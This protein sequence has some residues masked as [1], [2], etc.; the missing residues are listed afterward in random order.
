MLTELKLHI[1]QSNGKSA[2]FESY[3]TSPLKLGTPKIDSDRLEI[4]LMM[5]SAGVLKGDTFQYSIHCDANTK[6]LLTEQSYTKIFNTGDG[7]AE[8]S[9]TI[10]LEEN[11]S[12]YYRPCAAVPFGGSSYEGKMEVHLQK[13][14]EFLYADIVTA[15]RVGMGER[16]CFNHYRNRVCV[17]KEG[18]P[19]WL[20]HCLLE[21]ETMDLTGMLFFD[22]YTHQ[23]TLYY[24]GSSEREEKLLTFLSEKESD[25]ERHSSQ[26]KELRYGV[27]KALQGVCVRILGHTAQDIEEFFDELQVLLELVK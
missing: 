11:A 14:S 19:V 5:A 3:F 13:N 23:G 27:S 2:I 10:I 26:G 8:K 7:K 1:G 25:S 21:P 4:V 18:R 12:L 9:Q 16:F 22:S 15:G 6:T 17:W 20:D 24:Y